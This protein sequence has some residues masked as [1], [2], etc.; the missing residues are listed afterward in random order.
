ML[1]LNQN[2]SRTLEMTSGNKRSTY[3]ILFEYYILFKKITVFPNYILEKSHLYKPKF[4]TRIYGPSFV[5]EHPQKSTRPT[6]AKSS[7]ISNF[8]HFQN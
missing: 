3:Y 5:K 2:Q 6:E 8:I 7:C 1:D 4:Y